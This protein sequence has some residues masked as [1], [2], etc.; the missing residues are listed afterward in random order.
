MN[1]IS[2]KCRAIAVI[3]GIFSLLTVVLSTGCMS[4]GDTAGI[5]GTG[6][7]VR[8]SVVGGA[9]IG[10]VTGFGSIF[11]N[12][13]RRFEVNSE[14]RFI[15]DDNVL[16]EAEFEQRGVGFIVHFTVGDDVTDDITGGTAVSVEAE[17]I[18]KGPVT[19]TLPLTV[20]GQPV[21][22]TASTVLVNIPGN[23]V[24][25]LAIGDMVEVSGYLGMGGIDATRVEYKSTG[26]LEWELNGYV[27]DLVPNTSF[28]IGAQ[29]IVLNG[30]TANDC[31]SGLANGQL[32]EV[33]ATP[34]TDLTTLNTVISVECKQA[35][36]RVPDNPGSNEIRAELEG[37]VSALNA[38]NVIVVHGQTV[39]YNAST[40]FEGGTMDDVTVGTRVEAEGSLSITTGILA[41]QKIR[42]RQSLIRIEAPLYSGDVDPASRLLQILGTT[43]TA[44]ALTRDNDGIFSGG[45]SSDRQVEILGIVD[46]GGAVFVTEI[47]DIGNPDPGRIRIRGPVTAFSNPPLFEVAGIV[48]DTSTAEELEGGTQFFNLI[49]NG[50]PV[51]IEEGVYDPGAGVV[52]SAKI[53]IEN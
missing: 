38:P 22:V 19:G 10:T 53:E 4:N 30:V 3:A 42:L 52:N 24:G 35:G 2:G 47:K 20:M 40:V 48:V 49:D 27:S 32:A 29:S 23:A 33:K 5:G 45:L 14:T 13:D 8:V 9:G 11:I 39:R 21:V 41:A 34:D 6:E 26:I 37:I 18:V 28:S 43:A 51:R 15:I 25:N 12:D 36:V 44:N 31:E 1:A 16:S 50:T 17:N 7:P 46:G